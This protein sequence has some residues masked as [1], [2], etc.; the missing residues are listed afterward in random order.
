[1]A[2]KP[3]SHSVARRCPPCSL[4]KPVLL[5]TASRAWNVGHRCNGSPDAICRSMAWTRGRIGASMAYHTPSP[6]PPKRSP[7]AANGSSSSSAP[8]NRLLPIARP[9]HA[10][11]LRKR[12]L[13]HH[14]G[15]GGV[16]QPLGE[17]AGSGLAIRVVPVSSV[18]RILFCPSP[19]DRTSLRDAFRTSKAS[20]QNRSDTPLK[21]A[22]FMG[23]GE[24]QTYGR[25]C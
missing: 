1:V 18:R 24:C 10:K 7:R 21:I 17:H 16:P 22:V 9:R 3:V 20:F 11:P 5:S 6:W 25:F 19:V 8:G 13:P 23:R 15:P 2:A 12:S 4:G 14:A